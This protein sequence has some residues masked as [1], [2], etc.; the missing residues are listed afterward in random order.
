MSVPGAGLRRAA[1]LLPIASG[2]P[3]AR[4]VGIDRTES[5]VKDGRE[6]ADRLGLTNLDLRAMDILDVDD[7][8]GSFDFIVCHGVYSW[9]PDAVREKLLEVCRANLAPGG[10]AY[11]SF[12]AFPGWHLR[13]LS[14]DAMRFHAGAIADPAART[15][16][17]KG[18]W[19]SSLGPSES[20][21]P[22]SDGRW[23]RKPPGSPARKIG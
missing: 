10:V 7:S 4:V 13:N 6:R 16:R 11:V 18:S 20:R 21:N 22:P 8:L 3:G 14:R 9:V 2:L 15:G 23:P 19:I 1:N 5:Q 17:P 12:N